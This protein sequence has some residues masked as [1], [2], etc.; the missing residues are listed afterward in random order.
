MTTYHEQNSYFPACY[1]HITIFDYINAID[2]QKV[3]KVYILT[4]VTYAWKSYYSNGLWYSMLFVFICNLF[5]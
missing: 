2:K 1:I 5:I 4:S 3:L